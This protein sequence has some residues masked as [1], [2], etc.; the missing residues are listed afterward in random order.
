[1]DLS[2][3]NKEDNMAKKLLLTF[4]VEGNG[5]MEVSIENPKED[6]TYET[7]LAAAADIIPVLITNKGAEAL[8]LKQAEIVESTTTKLT[9]AGA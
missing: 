5:T 3:P 9:P 8:S 7:A 6:M 1:M 2:I 4:T